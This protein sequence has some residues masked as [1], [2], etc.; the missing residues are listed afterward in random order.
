MLRTLLT[1]LVFGS[2]ALAQLCDQ[3][4]SPVRPGWEWQYRV[5]GDNPTTYSVRRTNISDYGFTAIQQNAQSKGETKFRC[6]PEGFVPIDFGGSGPTQAGA[7]GAG[8]DLDVVVKSVRGVQVADFDKWE[9]GQRWSYMLELGGT[10][11]Q[12]PVRF[13]VEG[14]VE[15]SYRVI[16]QE[17][18]TVPAGRFSSLKV[19]VTTNIK[20]VGKAGPLSIP[21]NQSSESTV[22]FAEG[23]GMVKTVGRNNTTELVA[24]K[25]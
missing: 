1:F 19:Q 3:P 9:V 10:A 20:V 15:S 14:S 4:F 17:T 25:K 2:V 6:T 23:V 21:F 8:V 13:N 16:A 22:W 7:G 12:G 24:L 5:T 11:K 18:I